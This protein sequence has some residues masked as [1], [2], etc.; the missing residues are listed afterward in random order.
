MI[1]LSLSY[2]GYEYRTELLEYSTSTVLDLS[3]VQVQYEYSAV[4]LH[5]LLNITYD[6]T[7]YT[8][9]SYKTMSILD[10]I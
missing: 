9:I 2:I 1:V 8:Y 3:T 5:S 4:R 7:Y 10:T 6:F